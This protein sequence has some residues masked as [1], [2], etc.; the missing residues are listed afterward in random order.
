MFRIRDR[1]SGLAP[2]FSVPALNSLET[3][4][5]SRSALC[6]RSRQ[7]DVRGVIE[8]SCSV[9][10]HPFAFF[11]SRFHSRLALGFAPDSRSNSIALHHIRSGRIAHSFNASIVHGLTPSQSIPIATDRLVKAKAEAPAQARLLVCAS[12]WRTP[13]Q[14][15]LENHPPLIET[16]RDFAVKICDDGRAY[17]QHREAFPSPSGLRMW[18][19]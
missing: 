7:C 1:T 19:T 17:R 8:E 18:R 9:R 11:Y 5:K 10:A 15:R 16:Q 4:P 6:R 14:Q 3:T 12:P 2:D 13:R